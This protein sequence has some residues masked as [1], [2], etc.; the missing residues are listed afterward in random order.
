MLLIESGLKQEGLFAGCNAPR[1]ELKKNSFAVLQ[2]HVR[3]AVAHET[4]VARC[5]VVVEAGQFGR[6]LR[7]GRTQR[8]AA[9]S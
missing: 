1:A 3:T 9:P 6:R 5:L 7:L 4:V 2:H 8:A